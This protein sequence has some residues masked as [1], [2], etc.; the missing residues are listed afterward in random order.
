MSIFFALQLFFI[1]FWI[2]LKN[3]KYRSKRSQIINPGFT[4]VKF[5]KCLK[6]KNLS[7]SVLMFICGWNQFAYLVNCKN[8][9]NTLWDMSL[10]NDLW[11]K[12]Q[13]S[14]RFELKRQSVIFRLRYFYFRSINLIY[15]YFKAQ[16]YQLRR[17]GWK[18]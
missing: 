14:D 12:V 18:K 2:I 10:K 4:H 3:I 1:K 17:T 15:I 7:R 8:S 11:F 16:I 9:K 6:E 5:F 13:F